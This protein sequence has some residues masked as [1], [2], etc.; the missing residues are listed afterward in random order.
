MKSFPSY[1][2]TINLLRLVMGFNPQESQEN[3]VNTMGTLLGLHPI[4]PWTVWMFFQGFFPLKTNW[5]RETNEFSQAL[6]IRPAI[7][8]RGVGWLAVIKVFSGFDAIPRYHRLLRMDFFLY[9]YDGSLQDAVSRMILNMLVQTK[10]VSLRPFLG[11]WKRDLKGC[12]WH[13]T[14]W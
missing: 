10:D 1:S 11:W 2:F 7:S 5:L 12:W 6:I 4:V 3:I 8:G 14:R 9:D 13:P